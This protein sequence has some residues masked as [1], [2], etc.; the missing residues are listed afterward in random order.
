M[1]HK[2]DQKNP[3]SSDQ[4]H[5][6]IY[7]ALA[8]LTFWLV[9]SAWVFFSQKGYLELNLGVI[10]A[11]LF[12]IV[13]IPTAIY[14]VGR[15]SQAVERPSSVGQ[16]WRA[17]ISGDFDMRQGRRRSASASLEILLPMAAAAIGI[18]AIGI[19]FR[20]TEI[21]SHAL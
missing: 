13:A 2:P 10:S 21:G 17:W 1:D 15:E 11:L 14:L 19:V 16:S 18:T 12:M 5:P 7:A 4:L 3:Q 8:G 6:L 9:L 20:L